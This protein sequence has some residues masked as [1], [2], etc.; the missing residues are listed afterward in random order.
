MT[1]VIEFLKS[2]MAESFEDRVA[3]FLALGVIFTMLILIPL[4]A[5]L[6]SAFPKQ[7]TIGFSYEF[8]ARKQN[9]KGYTAEQLAEMILK[10]G[11]AT[12]TRVVS[13]GE[14]WGHSFE[15]ELNV[16][17]LSKPFYGQKDMRSI[18][19]AVHECGHALQYCEDESSSRFYA[20]RGFTTI[21][22]ALFAL[23]FAVFFI[24]IFAGKINIITGAIFVAAIILCVLIPRL[25]KIPYEKDA[26]RR[27]VEVLEE[28][29]VFDSEEITIIRKMLKNEWHDRPPNSGGE[30]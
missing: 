11:G 9:S 15:P 30:Y 7:T 27:A 28:H 6:H 5:I 8:H 13:S 2:V 24:L 20:S 18:C 14:E 16:V 17:E 19:A 10:Y 4:A 29:D 21:P 3:I 23:I 1:V 12:D 22:M 26:S 25:I